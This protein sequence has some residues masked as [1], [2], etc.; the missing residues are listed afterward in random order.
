MSFSTQVSE[1]MRT[2]EHRYWFRNTA[3]PWTRKENEAP[4]RADAPWFKRRRVLAEYGPGRTDVTYLKPVHD[5]ADRALADRLDGE[6]MLFMRGLGTLP[7]IDWIR[8]EALDAELENLGY[9]G[10]DG[11]E[12]AE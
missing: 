7:K 5:E 10:D 6:R 3:K 1:S 12:G 9:T 2:A 11:E 4:W 8:S